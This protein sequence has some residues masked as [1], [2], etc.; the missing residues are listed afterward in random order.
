MRIHQDRPMPG[1]PDIE[2]DIV[3]DLTTQPRVTLP[4]CRECGSTA[5]FYTPLGVACSYH[6]WEAAS[7]QEDLE[8]EFWIPILIDRTAL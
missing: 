6:A 4:A 5:K 8:G 1:T 3:I 7:D 2:P